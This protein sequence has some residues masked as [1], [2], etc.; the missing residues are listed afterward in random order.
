MDDRGNDD[1]DR[2][3]NNGKAVCPGRAGDRAG[4]IPPMTHRDDEVVAHECSG[5][6]DQCLGK[7]GKSWRGFEKQKEL[8]IRNGAYMRK[9][10]M[11]GT[12][13]LD[14]SD[15]IFPAEIEKTQGISSRLSSR[16]FGRWQHP[17]PEEGFCGMGEW[18]TIY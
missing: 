4:R 13:N 5:T 14:L 16:I 8:G 15:E 11:D 3:K 9:M 12:V 6:L 1:P 17:L 10:A 7:P 18:H 2:E